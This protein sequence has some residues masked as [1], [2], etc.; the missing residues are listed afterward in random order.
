[1][2]NGSAYTAGIIHFGA[3]PGLKES[4]ASLRAQTLPPAKIIVVDHAGR[5]DDSEKLREANADVEWLFPENLGY[6]SGA[7]RVIDWSE[8]VCPGA[9]FVLVMNP[10]VNLEAGF[11]EA[12]IREMRV[13]PDVALACGKLLRPGGRL[14]DS[15]GI[16]RGRTRRYRDRGSEEPN[17]G[18]FDSTETVFAASGAAM[19]IRRA[20][21][22]S[23]AVEGEIFD[24][25]FFV[26][27]EDTDLAWRA[28]NLGLSSLYV[29]DA[30]GV[31]VRG[32]RRGQ[33]DGVELN[34]R[35]HSFKNRYLEMIKNEALLAFI[36]DL[37]FIVAM[38]VARLG[39]VLVADRAVLAGYADAFRLARRARQKRRVIRWK[40]K[41]GR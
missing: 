7:N 24:E 39:Y 22:P 40:I 23:L 25:D 33:R 37:P 41:S 11:A 15:A 30:V 19:M 3:D 32:W 35:R 36:C 9:E 17:D 8:E 13:R 26:Y 10:D 6:A 20:I 21:L 29:A 16:E 12:L 4:L 28:R 27:H 1:M 18:R 2:A 31:H 38:E 5:T 14:I 34:I